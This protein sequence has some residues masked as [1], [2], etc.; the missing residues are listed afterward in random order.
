MAK[1]FGDSKKAALRARSIQKQVADVAEGITESERFQGVGS[2]I[3][4]GNASNVNTYLSMYNKYYKA[5]GGADKYNNSVNLRQYNQLILWDRNTLQQLQPFIGGRFLFVPGVMPRFM[6]RL[7]KE[8][9]EYMRT[10]FQSCV[11]SITGFSS[12]QLDVTTV[13]ALTEQNSHDVIVG[14]KGVTKSLTFTFL[15]LYQGL[16]IYKYITTWMTLIYNPGS[17]AAS[18][19]YF[20]ELEYGEGNHTM[21][22]IYIV[23]DPSFQL[24]E[25]ATLIYNMCPLD[26]GASNILDQTWGDHNTKEYSV[27][28]KCH[29]L[30]GGMPQVLKLAQGVLADI[31]A[32]TEL[33]DYWVDSGDIDNNNGLDY[34]GMDHTLLR[35]NGV[36]K[37][38]EVAAFENHV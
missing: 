30:P 38:Q 3:Y 33:H 14:G 9:T 31:V 27:Q 29:T 17:S 13:S 37:A 23:T 7:H 35:E 24:V 19:P 34:M 18:Y 5:M 32:E 20:T 15:A 21:N 12:R 36:V 10:V 25:D 28:F 4:Q 26:N 22:G 11:K 16:R 2:S 6:E 1:Q 8:E